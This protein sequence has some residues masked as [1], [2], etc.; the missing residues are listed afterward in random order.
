MDN[1]RSPAFPYPARSFTAPAPALNPSPPPT[2]NVKRENSHVSADFYLARSPAQAASATPIVECALTWT[3]VHPPPYVLDLEDMNTMLRAV[4]RGPQR[5]VQ[6][7]T[8]AIQCQLF[9]TV[10]FIDKIDVMHRRP[11]RRESRARAGDHRNRGRQARDALLPTVNGSK[12]TSVINRIHVAQPNPCAP[13]ILEA[14]KGRQKYDQN[15]LKRCQLA[16][17][18]EGGAG[19]YN[20]NLSENCLLANPDWKM[21]IVPK[22]MHDQNIAD[23]IDPDTAE[24]LEAQLEAGGFYGSQEDMEE[25]EAEPPLAQDD[26]PA[27][28]SSWA[29]GGEADAEVDGEGEDGTP[30]KRLKTASGAVNRAETRWWR[31]CATKAYQTDT[32]QLWNLGQ[33]PRNVL[34]RSRNQTK[35]RRSICLL[36]KETRRRRFL[37][38]CAARAR[39]VPSGDGQKRKRA[40][41][42]LDVHTTRVGTTSRLSHLIA[43]FSSLR[44][45]EWRQ[46]SAHRSLW[47]CAHEHHTLRELWQAFCCSRWYCALAMLLPLKSHPIFFQP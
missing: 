41:V 25:S 4:L 12:P 27:P 8:I 14:V 36:R 28:Q 45:S 43:R 31:G 10:L 38:E 30:A 3:T 46:Q 11:P 26:V 24:T 19:M 18:V 35:K 7:H 29:S 17:D 22:V 13:C 47:S 21:D 16:R 5:T 20:T 9:K 37:S 40:S 15:D 1:T 42:P 39:T 33:R 2:Y 34:A 6:L 32:V 23:L 44:S